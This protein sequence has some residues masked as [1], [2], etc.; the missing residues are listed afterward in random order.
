MTASAHSPHTV[1]SGTV[2][3]VPTQDVDSAEP[4]G[5]ELSMSAEW[6]ERLL[7]DLF[8]LMRSITG[9]GSRATL[10]RIAAE[11][12]ITV[13]EVPT[14]TPVLDWT[15]PNEW[16]VSAAALRAPDGSIVADVA[17]LNLHLVGYS[18]PI[19]GQFDLAQLSDHLHS[20][21]EQPDVVP[22]RTS[23][24][25][26]SWGFCLQD[27]VRAAMPPG[28]YD[29]DIDATLQPGSLSYGE[30]FIPGAVRDE[31]LISTH[32]CHPSL[33]NDNLSGIAAAV[34]IGRW[35]LQ[36]PRRLSYRIL[37]IPA[38][39]GAITWLA[40]HREDTHHVKHGVV[41]AGLGDAG[42]LLYKR[43][44][45][46]AAVVDR[47][48]DHLLRGRGSSIDWYPY[49]YDERQ[50]N[51]PGFDL[52]IGRLSRTMH[53]TYPEYHTS[54]DDLDF[55]DA[56]QIVRAAGVVAELI[57]TLDSDLTPRNLEPYGEPQ[58]GRRNLYRT[59]AGWLDAKS[60]EMA[61]LWLLSLADGSTD[62]VEIAVRSDL[63]LPVLV[64][65]A[66]DLRNA[67]LLS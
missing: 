22:Y 19:R 17:A 64:A 39:I 5:A 43:S 23:Y 13:V 56:H 6:T 49:G 36:E 34:G 1:G 46:G 12:P 53:G 7:A 63:P 37:F 32:T 21:P 8:P 62:L 11:L 55:V 40:L 24:Y 60:T 52:P 44:R 20:L 35:L 4:A 47:A 31:V 57:D 54:G 65:A 59:K 10:R 30:L 3:P 14:G 50:F 2:P 15:V 51:S 9:E 42:P 27:R 28:R 16:N 61:Y 18:T 58:L 29:V 45:Q 67:G 48:M 26:S 33:A 38:T 25:R 66:S 41:L